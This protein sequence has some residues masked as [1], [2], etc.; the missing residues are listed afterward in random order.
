MISYIL[1]LLKNFF[2]SNVSLFAVVDN[3]SVIDRHARI[4]RG[5][6]LVDSTIGRYSYI[7]GG[8]WAVGSDIGAFCSIARDVYIGLAGHTL[9]MMSTSPIFTEP[10]NGTGFSWTS[11]SDCAY[12]NGRVSIGND[13]WIGYGAKI[14]SGIS[15][16]NGAIVAAGAVVTKDVPPYAIVGGVPAH[17]IRYRFE[18]QIIDRLQNL[19]W[20]DLP[21]ARLKAKIE[22]F[23]TAAIDNKLI[24]SI[25]PPPQ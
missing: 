25:L 10:H 24:D 18:Q 17:I 19:K 20:W 12:T 4:N 7:G 13:V 1:G 5:A 2:R 8:S 22:L 14:M 16:G 3:R 15:I 6:K 23:Q 9:D 21:D 11:N